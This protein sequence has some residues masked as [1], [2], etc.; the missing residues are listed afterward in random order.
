LIAVSG[1]KPESRI[2]QLTWSFFQAGSMAMRLTGSTWVG[3]VMRRKVLPSSLC[4]LTTAEVLSFSCGLQL[5][6][7]AVKSPFATRFLTTGAVSAAVQ[8]ARRERLMSRRCM[9]VPCRLVQ[10]GCE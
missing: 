8:A 7:P 5:V 1:L 6:Q 3:L 2:R 4:R 10:M 9:M